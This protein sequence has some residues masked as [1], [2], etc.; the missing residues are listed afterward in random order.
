MKKLFYS[1]LILSIT[2]G[3][4]AQ[5]P[6]YDP[7][8][9]L[10]D[11]NF[12][13]G[14]N[15]IGGKYKFS[16]E[17]K[18]LEQSKHIRGMGSNIIKIS[19]GKKSPKAYGLKNVGAKTTLDLFKSVPDYKK[20][21]DMDFK[22]VMAWVHTCTGVKWKLGINNYEE[23]QLYKEMYE[24]ARYI[25]KEYNNTGKTFMIGN[26]EGDWLLHP[27][28]NRNV[29]PPQDHVENMTKWFQIRQ[30]AIEDAKAKV[31]HKNVELYHY[32]E[33]NL[34]LKGMEGN[35]CITKDIL[36]HVD[37]DLVSYSSYEATKNRNF[38]EK[39]NTLIEVMDYIENQ[40]KPKEDLPFSRRVFIGEYGYHANETETSQ[41]KQY[42]E[43]KEIMEISLMLNSPFA[44]HWQMYNNE[45][46]K[47]GD[48][49][50]MSLINEKGEKRALYYL[51][52]NYYKA[53]NDYLKDYKTEND[54]YPDQEEFNERAL[55]VL[56]SL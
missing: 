27:N 46:K 37:V 44:L 53:M 42:D 52:Q 26:W 54:T 17:S 50:N 31:E 40:L 10:E 35:T 9:P 36:P 11:Y 6:Q 18:L 8:I 29:N 49:K 56:R 24:F 3:T 28:Y 22:Y 30:R 12:V 43:T 34:A 16:N 19:L 45:Y 25:L 13:L 2:C 15:G 51:H 14:T 21:F 39:K 48:S 7:E 33:V 55:N 5:A 4:Y 23:K 38:K 47:N 41:Q 20:V 32:I 1:I